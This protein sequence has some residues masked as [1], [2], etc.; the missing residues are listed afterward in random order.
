MNLE[1]PTY[2]PKLIR[3]NGEYIPNYIFDPETK[4]KLI[5]IDEFYMYCR[6]SQRGFRPIIY[7]D[8]DMKVY[9]KI[10]YMCLDCRKLLKP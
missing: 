1:L 10:E 8:F 6:H 7:R 5:F 2:Q 4:N 3:Q 9:N